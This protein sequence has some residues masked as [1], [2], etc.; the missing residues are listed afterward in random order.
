MSR[1]DP[2]HGRWIL[3]LIIGGMVL[4]T[5]TFV[6][7]LEPTESV[8][9]TVTTVDEPPFP[10]TPSSST[11]TLPPDLAAFM[12]TVDVFETQATGFG[13]Q[14]VDINDD[15]EARSIQFNE[16]RTNFNNVRATVELWEQQVTDAAADA[17]AAL[18]EE[19][20]TFVTSTADL[21]LAIEDIVLGLEASDDGTLR[22]AA[23]AVYAEEIQDVLDAIQAI[24]DA[25]D[26]A[27]APTEDSTDT[28]ATTTGDGS[29]T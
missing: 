25:A 8:D 19:Y 4:L 14:I 29:S 27:A 16:A 9:V 22:R 18:A 23:V 15:W 3:P 24:R 2:K 13:Q 21:A 10:T 5:Y 11:S 17:P 7:T 20:V 26:A 28:T 12:V 6:S 1:S